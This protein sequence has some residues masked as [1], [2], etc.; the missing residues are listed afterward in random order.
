MPGAL[1]DQGVARAVEDVE[2][3]PV[4]PDS[5][6]ATEPAVLTDHRCRRVK[7]EVYP[8]I[9]AAPG[10]QVSGLLYRDVSAAQTALLRA[11]LPLAPETGCTYIT[12]CGGNRH[13]VEVHDALFD[14][15][16]E[17]RETG[18]AAGVFC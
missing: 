16:S 8:A 5:R 1:Q 7:G 4:D 3:R 11:V 13:I 18:L 9:V 10:E 6:F 15:A 2:A 17:R 12:I 14:L